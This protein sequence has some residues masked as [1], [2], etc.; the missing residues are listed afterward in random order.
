[1]L[2]LPKLKPPP[3]RNKMI[4]FG[5]K[6]A[7]DAYRDFCALQQSFIRDLLTTI[8][9]LRKQPASF[10]PKDSKP[11]TRTLEDEEKQ[12]IAQMAGE[13]KEMYE[14][15]LREAGFLHPGVVEEL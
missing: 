1:M 10:S 3:Q 4:K 5:E 2:R 13:D 15:L 11:A 14:D 6:E 7:L 12:L 9:E 8:T